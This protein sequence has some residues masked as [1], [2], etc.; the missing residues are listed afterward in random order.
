MEHPEALEQLRR[1][2]AEVDALHHTA[3][4]LLEH[5]DPTSLLDDV[6]IRAA[7][8]ASTEHAY[9]YLAEPGTDELVV[10]SGTG[11]FAEHIGYRLPRGEGLAGRVWERGEPLAVDDYHAWAGRRPGFG[12]IGAAVGLPLR[13]DGEVIGVI[14]LVHVEPGLRFSAEEI[15]LL[16]RFADLVSL[17]LESSRLHAAAR[18]EV[19]ARRRAEEKLEQYA[20]ELERANAELRE[21]DELKSHFVAVASHELRTPLTSLV[22]FASTMLSHWE[23]VSDQDK[24]Q[25][26]RVIHTQARHLSRLVDDLL[27]MSRIEAGVVEPRQEPLK[28][29]DAAVHARDAVGEHGRAVQVDCAPGLEVIADGDHLRQILTNYLTNAV[30]Y[31]SPPIRVAAVDEGTSVVVSVIDHGPGVPER[32]VPHLFE[33]FSQ[34]SR[35]IP[36]AGGTG[37]GLSIVQGLAEAAGGDAWYEPNRPHGAV[38][39]VRLPA[40]T[41]RR[42]E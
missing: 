11:L 35:H 41:R 39:S 22:G 12:W 17:A 21:T 29:R 4:G 15:A 40:P 32:F 3:V 2:K 5:R 26:V 16:S 28:V 8:L 25:Y 7:E 37:L 36:K 31:G 33:K 14:G 10:R 42:P 23:Q 18:Q 38:F 1:H 34:A 13:A 20:S 30:R 24:L 19:E 9:L 27:T 6:L